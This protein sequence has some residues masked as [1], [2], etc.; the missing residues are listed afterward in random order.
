MDSLA[1]TPSLTQGDSSPAGGA[2]AAGVEAPAGRAG[3]SAPAAQRIVDAT[4]AVIEE[5]GTNG[6]TV[7]DI[8]KLAGCSRATLYR[9]FPGKESLLLAALQA[10]VV[11]AA[12]GLDDVLGMATTVEDVVVDGIMYGARLPAQHKALRAL[13]TEDPE[14]VL[15]YLSFGGA[16]QTLQIAAATVAPSLERFGYS[17][18][19]AY[20][21]GEWLCRVVL[22]YESV[23]SKVLD[24]EDQAS[25]RRLAREFILPGL[26]PSATGAL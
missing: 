1:R 13:L 14:M 16:D 22:S 6:F 15:P 17:R 5:R 2:N 20:L 26:D 8:A 18:P 25:V 12:R 9:Y 23:P 19:A 11:R 4:I 24:F 21:A 3:I 7:D 10:E